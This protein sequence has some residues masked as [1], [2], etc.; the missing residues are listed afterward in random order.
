[1]PDRASYLEYLPE[2]NRY[3]DIEDAVRLI[4][5]AQDVDLYYREL[6]DNNVEKIMNVIYGW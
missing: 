2:Q 1:V 5:E 4:K 3:K 6:N